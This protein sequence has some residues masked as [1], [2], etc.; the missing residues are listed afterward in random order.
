MLYHMKLSPLLCAVPIRRIWGD[1]EVA[2][3]V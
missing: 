1:T 2:K 3:R